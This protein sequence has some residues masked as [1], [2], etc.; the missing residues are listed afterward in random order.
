MTLRI[1]YS[2]VKSFFTACCNDGTRGASKLRRG[3]GW[4]NVWCHGAYYVT[5]LLGVNH[6]SLRSTSFTTPSFPS[7]SYNFLCMACTCAFPINN[8][9]RPIIL[10]GAPGVVYWFRVWVP[11]E[12]VRSKPDQLDRW[13]QA[14][15]VKAP[16]QNF[17]CSETLQFGIRRRSSETLQNIGNVS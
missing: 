14:D 17:L 1:A 6:R 5:S 9:C 13:L 7:A 2:V 15:S 4:G 12:M 10:S 8:Y 16:N 11:K 3:D